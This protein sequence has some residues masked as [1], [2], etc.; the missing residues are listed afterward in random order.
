MN[1]MRGMMKIDIRVKPSR[2]EIINKYWS[3]PFV[4]WDFDK[5][6]VISLNGWILRRLR[7]VMIKWR[8]TLGNK[9]M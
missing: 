7:A 3:F 4:Y 8:R 9:N 6:K 5:Y 2:I 1:F